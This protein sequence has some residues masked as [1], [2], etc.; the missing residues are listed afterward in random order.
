MLCFLSVSFIN[1]AQEPLDSL[2]EKLALLG[3][4]EI[5]FKIDNSE[6]INLKDPKF[7]SKYGYDDTFIIDPKKVHFIDF[8]N[9]GQKDIIYQESRL[10][11]ATVLFARNGNEFTEIWNE[12]GKLVHIKKGEETTIYV[13]VHNI[14]C[15]KIN[16]L[17]TL[18]VKSDNSVLESSIGHMMATNISNLNKSFDSV[19]VSGTL[20]T[21]P[22]V[23]DQEIEDPCLG[24]TKKGNQF[25]E[26]MNV[27]AVVLKEQGHWKLVLCDLRN[28]SAIAWIK[29]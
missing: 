16:A 14:A 15:L 28:T 7:I 26:V 29:E 5:D 27:S 20:R 18:V 23:D 2:R 3:Q 24:Q 13:R 12:P 22:K 10:H 6:F 17:F 9:D 11:Q 21:T 1:C 8:N 25:R 19:V 4:A